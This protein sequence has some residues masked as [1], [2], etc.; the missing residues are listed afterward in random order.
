MVMKDT[1]NGTQRVQRNHSL[2]VHILIIKEI[3]ELY[4]L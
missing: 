1:L 3:S 4:Q 2:Q